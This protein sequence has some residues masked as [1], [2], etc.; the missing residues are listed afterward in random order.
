MRKIFTKQRLSLLRRSVT[1]RNPLYYAMVIEPRI[2]PWKIRIEFGGHEKLLDARW[3]RFKR[4]KDAMAFYQ[5]LDFL[6]TKERNRLN[7]RK[8]RRGRN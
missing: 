8:K 5:K 6:F 1:D 2:K 4:K 3:L 7:T